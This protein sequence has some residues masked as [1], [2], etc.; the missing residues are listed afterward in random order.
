MIIL[1]IDLPVTVR[2]IFKP[3]NRTFI[4]LP[5]FCRVDV[6]DFGVDAP[7]RADAVDAV[8][9][10]TVLRG[11]KSWLWSA[12]VILWPGQSTT[13][14]TVDV[15][16]PD[17]TST[18]TTARIQLRSKAMFDRPTFVHHNS[19]MYCCMHGVHDS[20]ARRSVSIGNSHKSQRPRT[21]LCTFN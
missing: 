4:P 21:T 3:W 2:P 1:N 11:L 5:L 17:Q 16:W 14:L 19:R 18:C 15:H 20:L 10:H 8:I 9:S 6:V 7:M 12:H 13:L